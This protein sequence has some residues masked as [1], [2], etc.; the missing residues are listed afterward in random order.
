MD[1]HR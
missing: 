1:R